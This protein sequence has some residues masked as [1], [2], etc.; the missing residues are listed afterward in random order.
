MSNAQAGPSEW[1]AGAWVVLT[2]AAGVAMSSFIYYSLGAFIKPLQAAFGWSRG[3]ITA[4]L[5]ICNFGS[6]ITVP[7]YGALADRI[8]VRRVALFGVVLYCVA[9]CSVGLS[10]PDRITW[11]LAWA[12]VAVVQGSCSFMIWT[13]A[14]TSRFD[15]SRGMALAL[16]AC[17]SG[18]CSAVLPSIITMLIARF[19]WRG[20]YIAMG[21]FGLVM[22]MPL[23]YFFLHDAGDFGR[24]GN[25]NRE[26]V[27]G[28]S[29]VA[30]VR[31]SQFW[32]LAVTIL[33]LSATVS[34]LN[35]HLQPMFIDR[36][37]S[38]AK[39]ALVVGMIGPSLIGGR[40][41]SGWALDRFAGRWVAAG[42]ILAPVM[43]YLL[44][45][46]ASSTKAYLMY[47]ITVLNGLACGAEIGL[48]AFLTSRYF[49]MK[50]YGTI[51]GIIGG[52]FMFGAGV[53]PTI[54]GEIYDATG[55][56]HL[57]LV[58]A[59]ILLLLAAILMATLGPYPASLTATSASRAGVGSMRLSKSPEVSDMP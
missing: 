56:Y 2:A 21:L 59:P 8:G 34:A 11:Y 37:L 52:V 23:A 26:G 51:Y 44:L 25:K 20:G 40:L 9:I 42:F 1:R 35:I 12:F 6:M 19:G 28:M 41:I 55:S 15:R 33:I 3:E 31:T 22:V 4:S 46:Q 49:G 47:V 58:T 53:A 48:I 36:G 13:M 45:L 5:L 18:V 7:F 14:V 50:Q 16:C 10:G 24:R 17:G 30:A 38:A 32:K 27:D 54:A 29:V 43:S 39:A 57:L